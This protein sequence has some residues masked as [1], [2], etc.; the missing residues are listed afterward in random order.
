MPLKQHMVVKTSVLKGHVNKYAILGLGISLTSIFIASILVSYQLTG[1]IDFAGIALAQKSNPALWALDL[2]PFIFA[3]WGQSF[4]YELVSTMETMLEDR[5]RELLNKSSDLELKLQYETNHD[6]LTN[7]P[8]QRLFIQ[9]I[10]QGIRQINGNVNEALAVIILRLNDFKEINAKYGSF[11]GNSLLVQFAE[12]LKTVLLEP[13]LLQAYMG[14]NIVARLQGA[15]FAILIPRLHKDHNLDDLL[16]K[17]IAAT[18]AQFMIDGNSIPISTTAGVSVYPSHGD[19]D[20][21]LLQHAS[22]SLFHADKE[23][24]PYAIY[25][26]A[27]G[28]VRNES[29]EKL[30]E[31]SKT[32]EDGA[33]GFLYQ[34]EMALKT[35]TIVGVTAKIQLSEEDDKLL[36]MIQDPHLLK[37]L[38]IAALK[39]GLQQLTHWQ[40]FNP[41]LYLIVPLYEGTDKEFPGI[42]EKLLKENKIQPQ[43]L[44]LELT[45]KTCLSDQSR[46][47]Q[48]LKML[49]KLGVKMIISD[50]GSGY[51]PFGYL[52]NFPINEI[53]IDESFTAN[54]MEDEKKCRIVKGSIK[55]A[56]AMDLET[57]ADGI[58]S[59][60]MLKKLKEYGCTYG[61]GTFYHPPLSVSD[62]SSLL[63][64]PN[65]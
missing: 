43:S 23:G 5:T 40:V 13:Y 65:K 50:F 28:S 36:P 12:K 41:D 37:R 19:T 22:A 4:C 7:L 39:N 35:D 2:T 26:P 15:E 29:R 63:Q 42:L 27:M 60:E 18:S 14:M 56:Q 62:L 64:T 21:A 55:L 24:L 51:S 10:N 32:I 3:Y 48:V 31:L 25:D 53:K 16:S 46:S 52:I 61:K 58:N 44:K 30:N 54:M 20:T 59:E 1:F 45:E 38:T 49:A 6:H 8:N 57:Y 34:P 17:I 9:R 33:I 11:N 47:L